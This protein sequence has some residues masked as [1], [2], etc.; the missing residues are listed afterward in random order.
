LTGFSNRL[1]AGW[2]I[3]EKTFL[4]EQPGCLIRRRVKIDDVTGQDACV[5]QCD[6]TRVG[7]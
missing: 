5:W 6:K 7:W 3:R 2:L 1:P 4:P